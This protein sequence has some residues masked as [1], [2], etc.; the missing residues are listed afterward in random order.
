MPAPGQVTKP[1]PFLVYAAV[2]IRLS[3]GCRRK[4]PGAQRSIVVWG[5]TG[6]DFYGTRTA[7]KTPETPRDG[8]AKPILVIDYGVITPYYTL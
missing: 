1:S 6:L 4:H 3:K 2:P 8:I 7:L 5:S